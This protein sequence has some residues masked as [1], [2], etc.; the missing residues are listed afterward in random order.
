MAL[1]EPHFSLVARIRLTKQE[2]GVQVQ[3]LWQG[4]GA[5]GQQ[6]E[7]PHMRASWTLNRRLAQYRRE[8]GRDSRKCAR[9]CE[10]S[11]MRDA[12]CGI[13][14]YCDRLWPGR[15]LEVVPVGW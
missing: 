9:R 15:H 3:I 1:H 12:L 8:L 13:R 10:H 7:Q 6:I 11:Q 5:T 4:R 14:V 2:L